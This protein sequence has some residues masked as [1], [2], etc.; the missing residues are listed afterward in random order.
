MA[1][2]FFL[3]TQET[4]RELNKTERELF[5]Y[6]VKNI[7]SVKQMSIRELAESRF[8]S[9]A[10]IF[11]FAQ[12]L[13]FSGYSD[14][15]ESL[16]VTSYTQE[17]LEIPDTIKKGQ[18]HSENYLK[19]VMETARVMS[20]KQIEE[21]LAVLK[22][23]PNIY[24]LTDDKTHTLG[25]YCERLFIGLDFHAYFPETAYQMQNLVNRIGSRDMI[26]ALSYSGEDA[27]LLDFVKRVF[28][29]E[30][31]YLLSIT[32]ADNNPLENLS[33]TNFY[34]FADEMNISNMDL[35]S[36]VAMLMIAELLMYE[37]I[38]LMQ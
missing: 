31:P 15:I 8:L 13:G 35:T 25:Q 16:I 9:T 2:D 6:V 20:P 3:A 28:L 11:R 19:N 24:I 32:R 18:N 36:G 33:D 12:K 10:T 7:H 37:Y 1:T 34:I 14:F 23:R 22:Q 26:I 17:N 27:V 5:E 4:V 29:K 21:V 38:S 30:K